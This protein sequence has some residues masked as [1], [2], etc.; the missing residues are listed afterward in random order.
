MKCNKFSGNKRKTSTDTLIVNLMLDLSNKHFVTEIF[1]AVI[2]PYWRVTKEAE[3]LGSIV[4]LTIFRICL[5][6][7]HLMRLTLV[8]SYNRL[9]LI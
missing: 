4:C 9:N 6:A 7:K 1:L 5:R 2:G 3:F 8:N